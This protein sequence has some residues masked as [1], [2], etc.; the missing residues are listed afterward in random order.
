MV[1]TTDSRN[2]GDKSCYGKLRHSLFAKCSALWN[3][4]GRP[5]SSEKI[6]EVLG[7]QLKLPCVTRW[8]SLFDSLG[9]VIE[10]EHK[11]DQ[12]MT[13]LQL[14]SFRETE[15]KFME[16]YV[17]VLQPIATALDRLQADK[18]CYYGSTIPTLLAVEK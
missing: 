7:R 16:E 5:K 3:S 2:A 9:V 1:A 18:A 13:T 14:P 6:K 15:L 8:N 11:L 12:L 10:H 4:A 17:Q